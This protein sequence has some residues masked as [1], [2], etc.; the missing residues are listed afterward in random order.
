MSVQI[1]GMGFV[2]L[3]TALLLAQNNIIVYG[4]DKNYK[5]IES[6][7]NNNYWYRDTTFSCELKKAL[8]SKRLR[9]C[10]EIIG[11]Q[12]Y[13]IAVQ[14]GLKEDNEPDMLSITEAIYSIMPLLKINDLIIIESTISLGYLNYIRDILFSERQDLKNLINIVYCPER[15]GIG[16][17]L[18]TISQ[19]DRVLGGIT[20]K[21]SEK[22]ILFYKSFITGNIQS[23]NYEVVEISKLTENSLRDLQIAFANQLSII[24]DRSSINIWD[25]IKCV[26]SHP[27]LQMLKP[28]IGVGGGCIPINPHFLINAFPQETALLKAARSINNMKSEYCQTLAFECINNYFKANLKRPIVAFMG[29]SYKPNVGDI[30]N[31]VAIKIIEKIIE[32]DICEII[33]VDPYIKA[34]ASMPL[35]PEAEALNIANIVVYL[36]AH[37]IFSDKYITCDKVVL[38]FVGIVNA[39]S[40][41]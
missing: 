20:K 5:T 27:H 25:V 4:Y 11:A 9:V 16:D 14:T 28:S 1:I 13:L 31:S 36:V 35:W 38:D 19:N 34:Y 40:A 6:I 15:L 33:L 3:T 29:L 21:C 30:R 7:Q 2:G 22:G 39:R 37:D 24:C 17:S 23:T 41:N 26:N 12:T 8:Q 10:N 32:L 18:D